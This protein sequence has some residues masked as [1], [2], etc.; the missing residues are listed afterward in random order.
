MRTLSRASIG[1][2]YWFIDHRAGSY[3]AGADRGEE[4]SGLVASKQYP[5]VYWF[6][7]DGAPDEDRAMLYA[8]RIDPRPACWPTSAGC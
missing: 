6:I 5:G 7:R 2:E 3:T 4:A 1:E 8:I